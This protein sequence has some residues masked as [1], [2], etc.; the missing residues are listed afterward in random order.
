MIGRPS[1]RSVGKTPWPR[2]EGLC[3]TRRMSRET[4]HKPGD[5]QHVGAFGKVR[6]HV[7]GLVGPPLAIFQR[8]RHKPPSR[9][10]RGGCGSARTAPA[11]TA[12]RGCPGRAPC[13][14][15][16]SRRHRIAASPAPGRSARPSRCRSRCC[17]LSEERTF[18]VRQPIDIDRVGLVRR[19]IERELVVVLGV[20]VGV[21]EGATRPAWSS[22]SSVIR[23]QRQVLAA[24]DQQSGRSRSGWRCR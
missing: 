24:D 5:R 19:R 23:S 13:R 16:G 17:C 21:P 14:C 6:A 3:P 1:G 2:K 20:G 4:A 12:G 7:R 18:A 8:A 10:S 9:W 22:S 15:R 11:D